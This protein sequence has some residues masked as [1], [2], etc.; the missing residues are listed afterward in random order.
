MGSIFIVALCCMFQYIQNV[1]K[2]LAPIERYNIFR[3][4]LSAPRGTPFLLLIYW[5]SVRLNEESK[6]I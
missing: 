4:D 5:P 3:K 1:A 2:F 6:V